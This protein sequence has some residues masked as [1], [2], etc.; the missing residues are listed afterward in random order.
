MI[1]FHSFC[2]KGL[3]VNLQKK[4]IARQQVASFNPV[5]IQQKENNSELNAKHVGFGNMLGL[6]CVLSY[7]S[8]YINIY[9]IYM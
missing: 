2:N 6:I 4:E 7:T 8:R 9:I 5:P 3:T 1:Y